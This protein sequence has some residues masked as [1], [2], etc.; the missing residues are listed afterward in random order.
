[1]V[2][3]RVACKMNLIPFNP[4]AQSGLQR[5]PRERVT[6]FADVLQGAGIV[7]TVR[8]TRGDDIAAACGQLAGEVRDRTHVAQ[9][10]AR[11]TIPLVPVEPAR[12]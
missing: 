4:F 12:R 7:T 3:D 5:S 6:A 8:R 11:G 10:L 2:F 9:R 1:L